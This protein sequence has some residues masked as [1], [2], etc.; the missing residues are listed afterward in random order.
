MTANVYKGEAEIRPNKDDTN[1]EDERKFKT[2][3]FLF[4]SKKI[5]QAL[6]AT[7]LAD[8][9]VETNERSVAGV[10]ERRATVKANFE[11]RDTGVEYLSFLKGEYDGLSLQTNIKS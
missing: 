11:K 3:Y 4:K 9:S 6:T 7:S 2:F 1:P 10:I 8:Y 5:E